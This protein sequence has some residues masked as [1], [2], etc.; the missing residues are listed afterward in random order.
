MEVPPHQSLSYLNHVCKNYEGSEFD[1]LSLLVGDP[2]HDLVAVHI[3][4]SKQ[5]V[6]SRY[7]GYSHAIG[8]LNRIMSWMVLRDHQPSNGLEAKGST[9]IIPEV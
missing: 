5:H 6:F 4:P 9:P 1:C 2:S 8:H 3:S 7:N